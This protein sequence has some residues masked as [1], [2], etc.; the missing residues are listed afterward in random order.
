MG[1]RTLVDRRGE[2]AVAGPA[3]EEAVVVIDA[4]A[5]LAAMAS[6]A[7]LSARVR[8]PDSPPLRVVPIRPAA[9]AK[10]AIFAV[11]IVVAARPPR[12]RAA[13]RRRGRAVRRG[14]RRGR[15]AVW[16]GRPRTLRVR[17]RRPHA[18]HR[19]HLHPPSAY[20]LALADPAAA[21]MARREGLA[22]NGGR[23][24]LVWRAEGARAATLARRRRG[25][26]EET[27]GDR[28]LGEEGAAA[29]RK[30]GFLVLVG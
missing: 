5:E 10:A 15:P 19:S 20:V 8:P 3:G 6:L 28:D 27:R 21:A 7:R 17:R 29:R 26:G 9:A 11:G 18:L 13:G 24:R 30:E 1:E 2:Q 23:R 16:R 14:R 25:I 4:D 22:S 12:P